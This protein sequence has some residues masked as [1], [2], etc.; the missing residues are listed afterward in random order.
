VCST[1]L[2]PMG[3]GAPPEAASPSPMSPKS[4]NKGVSPR[5]AI[6]RLFPSPNRD[7]NH[8]ADDSADP[9]HVPVR[10]TLYSGP[11]GLW[12]DFFKVATSEPASPAGPSRG[13]EKRDDGQPK[14][15]P[16]PSRAY[17]TSTLV[18]L[19]R[20]MSIRTSPTRPTFTGR[21]N[22]DRPTITGNDGVSSAAAGELFGTSWNA[23]RLTVFF[24]CALIS[25]SPSL[26]CGIH[27]CPYD[28]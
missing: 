8:L 26:R 14:K 11:S 10:G 3:E 20:K 16:T 2:E 18:S 19:A 17:S 7:H 21:D 27:T 4:P 28:A 24:R 6:A 23:A 1:V 12:K 5:L 13:V 22:S 25:H 15:V 9:S